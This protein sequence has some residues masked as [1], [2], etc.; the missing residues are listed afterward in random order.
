[1]KKRLSPDPRATRLIDGAIQGAERGATLTKRLLAFARRQEL[2]LEAT[3]LQTLV[4]DMVDFLRQSVGPGIEIVVDIA[5]DVAP[6]M[7]D[8]NQ[9][10]LALMN[11]AVNARDAMPKAVTHHCGSQCDD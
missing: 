3:E 5:D 1:M 9:F 6:I 10:E 8:A 2:K 7:I 11:L 4:P